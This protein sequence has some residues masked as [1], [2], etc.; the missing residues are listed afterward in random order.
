VD[1]PLRRGERPPVDL[2]PL[3]L[4]VDPLT[5]GRGAPVDAH[6][7]GGDQGLGPATGGDPGLRQRTLQAHLRH[8]GPSA[9]GPSLVPSASSRGSSSRPVSPKRS[10][11]S[12]PVPYRNGRPGDG[13]RPSSTTRR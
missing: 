4:R 11:N 6:P 10:R 2:D 3:S 9:S 8:H 7:T 5:D 12:K 1:V 13:A